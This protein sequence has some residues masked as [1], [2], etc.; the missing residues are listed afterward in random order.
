[1]T[2]HEIIERANKIY[3]GHLQSHIRD[4]RPELALDAG[5]SLAYFIVSELHCVHVDG[6]EDGDQ[7]REAAKALRRAASELMLVANELDS[8]QERE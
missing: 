5:D 6:N 4:G 1:M 2:I 8:G 3:P 7:R